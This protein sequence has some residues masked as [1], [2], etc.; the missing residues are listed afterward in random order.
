MNLPTQSYY[1]CHQYLTHHPENV[2]KYTALVFFVTCYIGIAPVSA[3]S[4]LAAARAGNNRQVDRIL[5]SGV[6]SRER[7]AHGETA[8]HWMAFHGNQAMVRRLI[9]AG[10]GINDAL[11]KGSTPLHL[12]AYNGH[13]GVARLLIAHGAKVNARTDD[14][15]T[16][17][18]WARRN[19]HG[20]VAEL[21]IAH[22][23]KAGQQPSG[24]VEEPVVANGTQA[25]RTPSGD[26]VAAGQR[27]IRMADLKYYP[28]QD[29]NL[30]RHNFP[31]SPESASILSDK[32]NKKIDSPDNPSQA[33]SFRIQ[34]AALSSEQRAV[35]AWARY[36]REHPDILEDLELM[37]DT[38]S[39]KGQRLHRVQTGLLTRRHA[40]SMCDQLKRRGQPC[41]VIG[42]ESL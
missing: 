42:P 35:D 8:L 30:R 4:L 12:A 24:E 41:M 6:E 39:S 28:G 34:L 3:G 19:G 11:E 17:L 18:D 38:V 36:L 27:K 40:E 5:N 7:G 16:P 2:M 29:D 22:G 21:L 32:Q 33:A 25:G 13:T 9:A 23:A 1:S 10:A 31:L 14:G 26:G 15:I 20:A 37:L